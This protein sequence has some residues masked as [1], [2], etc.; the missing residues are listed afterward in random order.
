M[1]GRLWEE[2]FEDEM[3][4]MTSKLSETDEYMKR[5]REE[6]PTVPKYIIDHYGPK[7]F[8]WLPADVKTKIVNGMGDGITDRISSDFPGE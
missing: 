1:A 8:L 7:G 4:L 2:E 3:E 6:F 5:V